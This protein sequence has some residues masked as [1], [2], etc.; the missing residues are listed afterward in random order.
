MEISHYRELEDLL[1]LR[2]ILPKVFYKLN[3][4]IIPMAFF[5]EI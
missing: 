5:A 3:A 1:L 4:V 2:S